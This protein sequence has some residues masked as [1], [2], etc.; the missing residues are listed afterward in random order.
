[1]AL[2]WQC[3]RC[4]QVS[5][6]GSPDQ[7]PEGWEIRSLPVRG[8]Q[9]RRSSGQMALCDACDDSLYDWLHNRG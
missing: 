6:L 5:K 1:M 4:G 2:V 3:E 7:L 8:S 9:G